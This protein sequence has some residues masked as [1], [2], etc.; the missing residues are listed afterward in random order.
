MKGLADLNWCNDEIVRSSG[1]ESLSLVSSQFT[2][3][4]TVNDLKS[5][6]SMCCSPDEKSEATNSEPNAAQHVGQDL[7]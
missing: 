2:L 6:G 1:K 5:T 7:I 3:E 4:Q